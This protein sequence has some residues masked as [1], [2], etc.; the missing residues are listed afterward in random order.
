MT[1]EGKLH[2]QIKDGNAAQHEL[3]LT[4]EAFRTLNA[5]YIDAWRNSDARDT[6]GREKLW[7]AST[8]LSRVEARLKR[9]V[10]DGVV[11][12]KE[13]ERNQHL[14]ELREAGEPKRQFLKN[15]FA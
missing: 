8:I 10:Q 2:E 9:I 13:I 7:L 1:D 15:P 5:E 11:A 3:R 4:D 12:A 6:A 14:R